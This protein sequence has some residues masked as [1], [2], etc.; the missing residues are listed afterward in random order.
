M[1][2]ARNYTIETDPK[3]TPLEASVYLKGLCCYPLLHGVAAQSAEAFAGFGHV[4]A[5]RVLG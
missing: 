1:A 5:A 3:A 4:D 2:N